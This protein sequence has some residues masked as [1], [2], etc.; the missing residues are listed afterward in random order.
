MELVCAAQNFASFY[1]KQPTL[2]IK[3]GDTNVSLVGETES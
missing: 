3:Q 2:E 1:L